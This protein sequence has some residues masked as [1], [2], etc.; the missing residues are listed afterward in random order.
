MLSARRDAVLTDGCG[1]PGQFGLS[2]AHGGKAGLALEG[3]RGNT[4]Q[5]CAG[6]VIL[7]SSAVNRILACGE[8]ISGGVQTAN[9]FQQS[10]RKSYLI[11]VVC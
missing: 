9:L 8:S 2:A 7:Q 3:A 6:I 10:G 11:G 5:E 1:T 4:R